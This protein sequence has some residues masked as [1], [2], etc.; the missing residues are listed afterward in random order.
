MRD[1]L[2][3]L[4]TTSYI[5]PDD[6][7]PNVRHLGP[8]VDDVEL[9]LFE[10]EGL[11]N[12]PDASTIA[13]LASLASEHNLTY[14]VHFPLDIYPGSQ[15]KRIREQCVDTLLRV[16]ELTSPLN[17]FGYVLHLTPDFYGREPSL[18]TSRW[19]DGLDW[20]LARVL[21][22]SRVESRM[23][24]AETLSYRFSV[25]DELVRRH[26]LSVTLDIG[27]IWLMGYSMEENLSSLLD[28]TRVCHVHGVK[29][30]K[31]HLGLDKGKSADIET[32]LS[33][34]RRQISLDQKSRVLTVE[35]FSE[36]D[37]QASLSLL[38]KSHAMMG[39]VWGGA[40]GY[41]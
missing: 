18:D 12:F 29:D 36:P 5:L 2:L 15:D 24:C 27:H 3:R 11:S 20:T 32:F 9:V 39:H 16:M 35:V 30:G 41:H 6:I 28:R 1:Q 14:T 21:S 4:G 34:L 7:L 17:P 38:Q 23:L 31:D 22:Q 33:A 40:H 13:E 8:L 10:S 19:L 26:D 25:V 37:L